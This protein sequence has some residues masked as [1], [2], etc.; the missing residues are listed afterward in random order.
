MR[1]ILASNS[2]RRKEILSQIGLNFEVI[3]SR[4]EENSLELEPEELVKHFA[5]MKARDVYSRIRGTVETDT[6]VIGSDTIVF[7]DNIMGKPKNDADA[8]AMLRRLSNREHYVM[9]GVSVINAIDGRV[10]TEYEKTKV[11]F[12][13]ISDDEIKKYISSGEPL[14]KAGAYAIQGIGSLF[15]KGIEG[16]YFNVVGFPIFRFSNIMKALGYNLL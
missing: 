6:F 3:P 1:L 12:R 2:P 7:C 4:F 10:V 5:Y 16:C 11:Y 8:F 15:V 9:T 13:A 14:D